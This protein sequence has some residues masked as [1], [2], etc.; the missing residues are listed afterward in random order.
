MYLARN[1]S[2]VALSVPEH[3]ISGLVHAVDRLLAWCDL[4]LQKSA[5]WLSAATVLI[6]FQAALIVTHRAWLDEWQ[7][8][9]LSLQSP[10]FSALLDNLRYEG[11]PPLWYLLLRGTSAILPSS[12][13]LIAVQL[14]IALALDALILFKAPLSRVERLLFAL[15]FY[16]VVDYATISRSLGLGVLLFFAAIFFRERRSAWFAV[17]LLPMVDF[18]FGALSLVCLAIYG[19]EK[20][21]WAPG[22]IL[23]LASAILAAWVV[24]P[25]ADV[26]PASLPW[27][28]WKDLGIQLSRFGSVLF[29]LQIKDNHLEWGADLPFVIG[30]PAGL[31]LLLLGWKLCVDRFSAIA[32]AM[33][34]T[35]LLMFSICVYPLSSR[36]VSLIGVLLVALVALGRERGEQSHPAL[37][38]TWLAAGA[39]LGLA[40]AALM[41]V[42]PFDTSVEAAAYIRAH[43]LT[44]KHWAVYPNF[45]SQGVSALTGMEFERVDLNCM[46]SFVR[47][48]HADTIKRWPQLEQNLDRIAARG[49]F[50]L[51]TGHRIRTDQLRRPADY[52]LLAHIPAGYDGKDY[53]LYRV[54]PELP[55][56]TAQ[57]PQCPPKRLALRVSD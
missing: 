37:F 52:R 41:F 24:R 44:R 56:Q 48:N 3:P 36:H 6:A 4:Q 39:L 10:G 23:W 35:L 14:P 32:F 40:A 42:T 16:V 45:E 28:W 34:C 15:N 8:L 30:A 29:P 47:W 57:V 43:G 51:M 46:Q 21:M 18:L 31:A 22:V 9:Q 50:Y 17:A 49:G 19:R 1:R 2:A 54:R 26:V 55:E 7:A 25:A 5:V 33:F 38:R 27:V 20:R 53:F 13:A 11:H 12:L